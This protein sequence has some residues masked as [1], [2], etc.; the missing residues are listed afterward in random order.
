MLIEKYKALY[1][2][3]TGLIDPKRIFHDPLHTFAFGTDASF[4]RLIPKM[5]IKSKDEQEVSL[6]LRESS[7]LSIPVTFRAGGTSL[8]G[9]AISDSVLVI[10][11]NHWKKF[12][13]LDYGHKISLQP[14]LTR[15][16]LTGTLRT[17][18]WSRSGFDQRGNDWRYCG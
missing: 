6:I 7:K 9:Q 15:K 8:S 16:R 3:L 2:Q 18:N 11:G 5:V 17:K 13:V 4:Y 10:A 12:K 14:G 1:Q